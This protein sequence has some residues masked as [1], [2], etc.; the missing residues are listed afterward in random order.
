MR[1]LR[2]IFF[3]SLSFTLACQ[4]PEQNDASEKQRLRVGDVWF[5]VEVMRSSE[6]WAKG[7]MFRES[8]G[9]F[10]GMFFLGPKNADEKE[11]PLSFWMKNTPL[12]LD[13]I[14]ISKDWRV[15]H[16]HHKAEPFS[17]NSISSQKPATHVLEILGGRAKDLGLKVGMPVLWVESKDSDG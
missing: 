6:E 7:M 16:I 2:W 17:E 14:F 11:R 13:M 10:E 4:S 1:G 15:V 8:L 5:D 12:S 3:A 9:G